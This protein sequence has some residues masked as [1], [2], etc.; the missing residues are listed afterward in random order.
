[1]SS[2]FISWLRIALRLDE[3]KLRNDERA[4]RSNIT[5]NVAIVLVIV[6][7]VDVVEVAHAQL[8]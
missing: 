5:R 4:H 3:E 7:F 1:M 6:V 8:T 2:E